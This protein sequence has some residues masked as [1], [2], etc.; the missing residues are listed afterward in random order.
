[1][2]AEFLLDHPD[3]VEAEQFDEFV[4]RIGPHVTDGPDW[5][6]LARKALGMLRV[7]DRIGTDA[8][9][10]ASPVVAP[11]VAHL[12]AGAA[13]DVPLSQI[14]AWKDIDEVTRLLC[15]A[16]TGD[17][18]ALEYLGKLDDQLEAQEA[19]WRE[20]LDGGVGSHATTDMHKTRLLRPFVAYAMLRCGGGDEQTRYRLC[21]GC[22][23]LPFWA[24]RQRW[25]LESARRSLGDAK[26]PADARKY[27]M[28]VRLAEGHVRDLDRA[29]E[30]SAR[31][32]TPEVVGG[33]AAGRE[34]AARA[35]A[36]A[37]CHKALP[38]C[39]RY[40][41]QLPPEDLKAMEALDSARLASVGHFWR[42]LAGR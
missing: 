9:R 15:V 32:F 2:A 4:D 42:F 7:D 18:A 23:E 24:W 6:R 12:A 10:P 5:Q 29:A 26:T 13:K 21:K 20:A 39:L 33:G 37:D 22:L 40:L 27:K 38:L 31:L 8:G 3:A 28:Q 41:R 1:V 34:A 14:L 25:I 11:L 35:I 17:P 16:A 36:E 30:L 19:Q